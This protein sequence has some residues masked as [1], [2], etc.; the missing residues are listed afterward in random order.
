VSLREAAELVQE[1]LSKQ[2][3]ENRLR[4]FQE[5]AAGSS[6]AIA[7]AEGIIEGVLRE[8]KLH[9]Y[10]MDGRAAAA[11]IRRLV[12]G[13][14]PLEDIY[15]DPT[16]DEIRVLPS[17]RVY[18]SRRGKNEAVDVSLSQPEIETLIQRM[19]PYEETGSAL[20]ESSPMMELVRADVSRLTALCKPVAKGHL[21]VLR[22][23]G[24][25]EMR[26]EA[27]IKLGTFDEKVWQVLSLLVRGRRNILI[28]G[29]TKS[30][31]TTLLK[32]LIGELHP[33][34]AIRI[35]DTDN[36]LRAA[37][38]YPERDIIEVEAHP[39]RGADM[40]RLFE[41]IL[42]LS[43]DVIIVGEF[44]GYGEAMEAMRACTRGHD[45]SMATAH[46]SD[47]EEA[48]RDTATMM[49]EEGLNLSLRLAME[50]VARAFN[51]V[52]QMF[53]DSVCGVKKVTGITEIFPA[54]G[55]IEYRKLV[56]WRPHTE[57]DYLG[58]GEWVVLGAPGEKSI[59]KMLMH[60]VRRSEIEEVFGH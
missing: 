40:K 56:E 53:T 9:V 14:G 60:G 28:S 58:P 8:E 19:I 11:E 24:T 6:K 18:V 29:P 27:L 47:P 3:D 33:K 32:L 48:V 5:A 55:K 21:F 38:F 23:H 2:A 39:E 51:I 36:E 7:E 45:G 20:N 12:W 31:K 37:E 10:G 25:I 42:R 1:V 49:L 59:R 26:P 41:K 17:G 43:P 57:E 50:R 46:F 44:R 35:L 30:G 52:V 34:L 22:K 13:L 15:R 4:V 54:D 16:V